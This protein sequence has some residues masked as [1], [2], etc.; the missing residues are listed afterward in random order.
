MKNTES[1][2]DK[3]TRSTSSVENLVPLDDA[4]N[5][6]PDYE[7]AT[8]YTTNMAPLASPLTGSLDLRPPM[9]NGESKNPCCKLQ[10]EKFCQVYAEKQNLQM[11]LDSLTKQ[12]GEKV[13]TLCTVIIKSVQLFV[14]LGPIK[15][16]PS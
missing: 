3:C 6:P 2:S 12:L 7:E 11:E 16:D 5:P 10:K 9:Q 14:R 1:E 4:L 8:V 13:C 15:I